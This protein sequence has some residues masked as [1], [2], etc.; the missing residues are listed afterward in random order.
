M[1]KRG[2]IPRFY[3]LFLQKSVGWDQILSKLGVKFKPTKRGAGTHIAKCVFHK[4]E[5]PSLIFT[6]NGRFRCYGCGQNGDK[7]KFI[8]LVLTHESRNKQKTCRWLKKCF[9]IDLPWSR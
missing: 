7:F 1:E 2:N 8:S 6:S 4:E 9:G 5:T 3:F